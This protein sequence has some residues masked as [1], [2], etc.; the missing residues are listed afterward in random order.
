VAGGK[1]LPATATRYTDGLPYTQ[2]VGGYTEDYQPTSTTLTL[3]ESIA[4][5]WGLNREY[6]YDYTYTD[7]GL[8]ESATLP[9]VGSLPSEK[10]L[11]R[12]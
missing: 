6:R 10:L 5:T 9:A 11:F 2:S 12:Y 3:P 8:T 7:T 4:T 1:G